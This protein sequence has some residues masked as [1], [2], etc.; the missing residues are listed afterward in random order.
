MTRPSNA[1]HE[2]GTAHGQY[3]GLSRG[4]RVYS[5]F[6]LLAVY[7]L[8]F[9]DRQILGVLAIPIKAN[10]HLNDTELA[11]LGGLSFAIFYTAVA[12]PVAWMAD[13]RNR[14]WIVTI[15]L[16]VWSLFTCTTGLASS[17]AQLFLA[18]IGVGVGEAGGT[19]PAISLITDYFPPSERTRALA[20]YSFGIPVGSAFGV[21]I[22]GSIAS[23]IDWR[24]AFF[25]MGAF[26]LILVPLFRLTMRE[27][28][29]RPAILD[30]VPIAKMSFGALLRL[31]GRKP[32]FWAMCLGA[33][34]CSVIGYGFAFWLP[35]FFTRSHQIPLGTIA[36]QYG[37]VVLIGGIAGEWMGGWIS[38]RF[39]GQ[40]RRIYALLPACSNLVA[41][42]LYAIGIC[43]PTSPWLI[44]YFI[45]PITA[46]YSNSGAVY[47]AVHGLVPANARATVTSL[48]LFFNT[49][50]GLGAGSLFFGLFSDGLKAQFGS[51]ALRYTI[52]LALGFLLLGSALY[53]YA[54]TR[55]QRDT[56]SVD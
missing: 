40:S 20:V 22:G 37:A 1:A 2:S 31:V 8:A 56:V 34:S 11:M 17:F 9:I 6:A 30:G 15:A 16:G 42:V 28:E 54:S 39:G 5:L 36:L 49:V 18:R 3:N 29:R 32:G 14:V 13:R 44:W 10:L 24:T 12:I 51:E 52:L 25:A 7:T 50:L 26:G 41:A 43:L 48:L 27:P 46:Y 38:D 19:T 33:S 53:A 55:L 4:R 23:V 35:S 21:F 47:S 45:L